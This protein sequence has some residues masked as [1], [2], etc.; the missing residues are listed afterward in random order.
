M[1]I[2]TDAGVLIR[3]VY[4]DGSISVRL[5][6][7]NGGRKVV[8]KVSAPYDFTDPPIDYVGDKKLSPKKRPRTMAV[9]PVIGATCAQTSPR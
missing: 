3:C 2:D 8:R 7:E 6:G 9:N 4:S 1:A 5:Y